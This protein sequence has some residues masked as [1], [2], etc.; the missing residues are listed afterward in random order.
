[1]SLLTLLAFAV[2]L[3]A[4][5]SAQVDHSTST[6]VGAA[7]D[8]A[9]HEFVD[10][11]KQIVKP[12]IVVG[13]TVLDGAAFV[14]LRTEQGVIYVAEDAFVVLKDAAEAAKYAAKYIV[15][16]AKFVV[17][18]TAQGVRWVAVEALKAGEIIF[19]AVLDLAELVVDDV[20][21]V[22]IKLEDGMAFVVKEAVKAGQ[23]VIK[24]VKYVVRKTAD[25]IVWLTENTWNAIKAGANWTREKYI[26]ADIRTRL[27]SDLLAGSGAPSFDMEFFQNVASDQH[28][29]S[30]LRKLANA[31]YAACKAFRETY[32]PTAAK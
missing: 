16:G 22:L 17:V 27:S 28:N 25:G 7:A 10:G 23:V 24:G 5:A 29:S 1:M 4:P 26:V 6:A 2:A 3:A 14:I 32:L 9:G 15:K 12:F 30:G 31:S 20:T 13:R 21:F 8:V 11:A 19:D 18:K